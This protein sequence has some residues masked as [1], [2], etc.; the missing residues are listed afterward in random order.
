MLKL[1][2]QPYKQLKNIQDSK[3]QILT[4]YTFNFNKNKRIGYTLRDEKLNLVFE[5]EE[6]MYYFIQASSFKIYEH[7]NLD[8]NYFRIQVPLDIVFEWYQGTKEM[9]EFDIL[10]IKQKLIPEQIIE[11]RK[12]ILKYNPIKGYSKWMKQKERANLF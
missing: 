2:Q 3:N 10:T 4:L 1:I 7:G 8:I 9:W 6:S 12:V 5:N 11:H